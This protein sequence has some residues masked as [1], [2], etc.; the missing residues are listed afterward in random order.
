MNLFDSIKLDPDSLK[1]RQKYYFEGRACEEKG[2]ISGAINAYTAYSE[3]L[4]KADQHIPFEWIA[5]LHLLQGNEKESLKALC[6]FA[7]G[8]TPQRSAEV[9]KEIGAGFEKIGDPEE[10]LKAY[11][12]SVSIN[13]KIGLKQKI[14]AL[15][16][17]LSGK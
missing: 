15:K 17:I 2:D 4:K 14:N 1:M 8:C 11:D 12:H 9:W 10:A 3:W 13:P 6:V 16:Y 7:E 5:H